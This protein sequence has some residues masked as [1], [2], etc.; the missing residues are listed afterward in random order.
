MYRVPID[1]RRNRE[2]HLVW[3][4]V[5]GSASPGLHWD[6]MEDLGREILEDRSTSS[7]SPNQPGAQELGV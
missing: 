2:G 6:E 3:E 5:E 4:R 1:F 7:Y